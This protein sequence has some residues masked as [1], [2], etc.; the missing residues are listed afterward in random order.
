MEVDVFF[1]NRPVEPFGMSIHLWGLRVRVPMNLVKS[2]NLGVKGFHELGTIVGQDKFQGEGKQEGDQ[3][4]ELFGS[5]GGMTPCCPCKGPAGIDIGEGDDVSTGAVDD[6]FN[7]IESSTVPRVGCDEMLWFSDTFRSFPFHDLS[8][9][10]HLHREHAESPKVSDE[11]SHRGGR[12]TGKPVLLAERDHGFLNFLFAE[13]RVLG[14]LAFDLGKDVRMPGM[15]SEGL[16]TL[17]AFIQGREL[18]LPAHKLMFP[19]EEGAAFHR[20]RFLGGWKPVLVPEGKDSGFFF[21]FGGN[22]RPPS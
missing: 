12:G 7:G 2:P 15:A 16:R 14:S 5:K 20:E 10:T 22:H 4:K 1:L 13:I 11:V 6:L 9:V 18:S 8:I 19:E 3:F 21:C 17:G